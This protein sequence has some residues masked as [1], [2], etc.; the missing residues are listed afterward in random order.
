ME[1]LPLKMTLRERE[2]LVKNILTVYDSATEEQWNRGMAW[3]RNAHDIAGMIGEGDHDKGAGVIAALSANTGWAQNLLMAIDISAGRPVRGLGNSLSKATKILHGERPAAT[4]GAG[5][6]TQNFYRNI[7][8]PD[9][10]GPVTIDRH[11]HDIARGVPWGSRDRG[12]ST[13]SRYAALASAYQAA[14]H[15]RDVRPHELQAVCWVAWTE[16]LAGT[17]TRGPRKDV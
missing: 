3:Y 11:A 9:V 14:A 1:L 10:S 15:S 7:A 13:P 5:R 12:L 16:R 4:L 8:H 6:K 2:A 17:S